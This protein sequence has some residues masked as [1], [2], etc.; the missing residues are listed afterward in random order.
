MNAWEIHLRRGGD[1]RTIEEPG[2]A[3]FT[4]QPAQHR[5]RWRTIVRGES[6][7]DSVVTSFFLHLERVGRQQCV[8]VCIL[9]S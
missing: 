1:C 8:G 6:R 9:T 4:Y 5:S 2:D 3:C 7:A